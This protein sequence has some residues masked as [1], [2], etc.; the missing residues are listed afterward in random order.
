MSIFFGIPEGVSEGDTF[1]SRRDLIDFRL[2]RSTQ[3]GIDGNSTDGSSAIVISGGYNDDYDFF[4]QGSLLNKYTHVQD[5]KKIKTIE[6]CD[7]KEDIINKFRT[8]FEESKN[9]VKF[10]ISDEISYFIAGSK[11]N[12]FSRNLSKSIYKIEKNL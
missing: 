6:F 9:V 2:H 1:P 10:R 4:S 12:T 7:Q 8:L 5:L 11:D 3:R